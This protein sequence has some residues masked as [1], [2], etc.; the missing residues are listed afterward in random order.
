MRIMG[1]GRTGMGYLKSSNITVIVKPKNE[2]TEEELQERRAKLEE[3]KKAKLT[4]TKKESKVQQQ[5]I[6]EEKEQQKE[7]EKKNKWWP[8]G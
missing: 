1:R 6:E 2:V 7:E 5:K 3:Q 4:Q 8:W